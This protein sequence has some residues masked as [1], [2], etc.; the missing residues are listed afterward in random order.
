MLPFYLLPLLESYGLLV[1]SIFILVPS[2]KEWL[3]V[4]I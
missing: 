4:E 2:T 3:M 1:V